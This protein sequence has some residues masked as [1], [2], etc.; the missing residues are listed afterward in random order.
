MLSGPCRGARTNAQ[1]SGQKLHKQL[2]V[3]V[4]GLKKRSFF[5]S[6]RRSEHTDLSGP[7]YLRLF[8]KP[9]KWDSSEKHGV[10][11]E[12]HSCVAMRLLIYIPTP[13]RGHISQKPDG[14]SRSHCQKLCSRGQTPPHPNTTTQGQNQTCGK[15]MCAKTMGLIQVAGKLYSI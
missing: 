15:G 7:V 3:S 5:S 13:H 12:A 10:V 4:S 11:I 9:C 14:P 1:T 6:V 2:N 8:E